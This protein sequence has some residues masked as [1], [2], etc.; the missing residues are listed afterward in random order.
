MTLLSLIVLV[1]LVCLAVWI[2]QSWSPPA[3][4]RTVVFVVLLVVVVALLLNA[5]G[6]FDHGLGLNRRL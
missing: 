3:P 1:V 5:F 4:I 6:L 2:I